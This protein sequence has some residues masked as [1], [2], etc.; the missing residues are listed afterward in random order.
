MLYKALRDE[1]AISEPY[2]FRSEHCHRLR[3]VKMTNQEEQTSYTGLEPS[4]S[5]SSL[6]VQST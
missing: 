5:Q 4:D 1:K 6:E 2:S 3:Q